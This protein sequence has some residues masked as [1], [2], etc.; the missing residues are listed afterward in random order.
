MHNYDANTDV[1]SVRQQ[2]EFSLLATFK[3]VFRMIAR[4]Q[5]LADD[6]FALLF[7]DDIAVHTLFGAQVRRRP[8]QGALAV[9]LSEYIV[10]HIPLYIYTLPAGGLGMHHTPASIQRVWA[11]A[12]QDF[13]AALA[14]GA[15][16][17]QADGLLYLGSC[18]P[19][20]DDSSAHQHHGFTFVKCA[21]RCTHAFAVRWARVAA[22]QGRGRLAC[23][24]QSR[25]ACAC[26]QPHL[27]EQ[28]A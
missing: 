14:Y 13:F 19:T 3:K 9:S 1:G 26:A 8:P 7:E 27:V 10:C 25:R 17:A 16:L 11:C 6:Q 5:A 28:S 22:L 23:A 2:R 18:G 24:A 20:C 4:Q 21:S 12:G 15:R